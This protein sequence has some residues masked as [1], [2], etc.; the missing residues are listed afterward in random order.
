MNTAETSISSGN[1]IYTS[2]QVESVGSIPIF[3]FPGVYMPTIKDVCRKKT[4]EF[5]IE[6]PVI[7]EDINVLELAQK[8]Y[9]EHKESLL[10]KYEGKYIA[11]LN[12]KV[13]GSGKNFSEFAQR[14]YKKYGYQ[15]IYM[16]FVEAKKKIVKIP[17][18]RIKIL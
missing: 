8:Y 10:R 17:S 12:D 3:T 16:S 13:L 6:K 9:E 4:G 14:I 2:Q 1:I 15:T 5:E 11:I 7:P 18:P